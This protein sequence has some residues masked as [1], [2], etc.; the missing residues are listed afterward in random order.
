MVF[1]A[2]VDRFHWKGC[3]L[4]QRRNQPLLGLGHPLG[5]PDNTQ[6]ANRIRQRVTISPLELLHLLQEEK[7]DHTNSLV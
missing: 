5:E 2:R 4:A 1:L 7:L 6:A 3:H